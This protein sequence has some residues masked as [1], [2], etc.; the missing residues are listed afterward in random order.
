MTESRRKEKPGYRPAADDPYVL[1]PFPMRM[2]GPDQARVARVARMLNTR[3]A[4]FGRAAILRV[5][6]FE[7]RRLMGRERRT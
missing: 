7:E 4:Q 6:E 2:R 1:R 3:P 5:L